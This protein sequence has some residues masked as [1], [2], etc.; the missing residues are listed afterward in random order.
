MISAKPERTITI[1]DVLVQPQYLNFFQEVH[2]KNFGL[3]ST[4][5]LTSKEIQNESSIYMDLEELLYSYDDRANPDTVLNT[6]QRSA[7]SANPEFMLY[8]SDVHKGYL[9][10]TL[11]KLNEANY[12][13]VDNNL[14]IHDGISVEFLFKFKDKRIDKFYEFKLS[15]RSTPIH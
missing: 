1:S 7:L 12:K 11:L 15:H 5:S 4:D 2:R 13:L 3:N 14:E 8:F 10:A 9:Y 6:L